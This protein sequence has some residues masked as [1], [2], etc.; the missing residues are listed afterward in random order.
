MYHF[1]FTCMLELMFYNFMLQDFWNV[2]KAPNIFCIF[3]QAKNHSH[4][5]GS[6][7]GTFFWFFFFHF[8][9]FEVKHSSPRIMFVSFFIK[10]F[11]LDLDIGRV[12]TCMLV[13]FHYSC[14]S[15][16]SLPTSVLLFTCS[17]R[18]S[19]LSQVA[20]HF[21]WNISFFPSPLTMT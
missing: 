20:W 5:L 17:S 1:K 8:K 2:L 16:C 15:Q 18:T 12:L 21:Q 14:Q 4:E 6:G 9:C 13:S 11:W 7:R 10:C 3:F 19:H